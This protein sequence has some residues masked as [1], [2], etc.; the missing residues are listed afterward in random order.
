MN[1]WTAAGCVAA[2]VV[3][4]TLGAALPGSAQKGGSKAKTESTI[5]FVDLSE[6]TDKIKETAEWQT[7]VKKF[8]DE[9]A[10]FQNEIEQMNNLRFL[11]PAELQELETLRAK[12]QVSDGEK[13]RINALTERSAQL[14]GEY[15]RIAM[16]EKPTE[17]QKKRLD[18]LTAMRQNA[19]VKVQEAV[20]LKGQALQKMEGEM[21][22]AMQSR[23][24]KV[25]EQIAKNE[26]LSVVLDRQA[27]L[28]G[29]QDLTQDVAK[30]LGP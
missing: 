6:V 26:G 4:G 2:L 30:K 13:A 25:V 18:E 29:G 5:G 8:R 22:E 11:S 24:L 14:D 10:K 12:T 19:S 3:A 21:L 9:Q 27:I 20:E 23:I 15:Q 17:E 28:Y 16:V 1:N 7:N